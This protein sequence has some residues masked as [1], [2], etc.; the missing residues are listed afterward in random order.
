MATR[1]NT[2]LINPVTLPTHAAKHVEEGASLYSSPVFHGYSL[3]LLP[4]AGTD[5]E[6]M[7]SVIA[8]TAEELET[9]A[10]LPHL[11]VL[12]GMTDRSEEWLFE[13]MDMLE[14]RLSHNFDDIFTPHL[15]LH[16]LG[17][18][19]LFFQCVYAHPVLTKSITGLNK[20][21]CEVFER[22]GNG[23]GYDSEYMPHLSLIYG[24]LDVDTKGKAMADLAIDVIGKKFHFGNLQLWKT[25]GLHTDWKCVKKLE[26]PLPLSSDGVNVDNAQRSTIAGMGHSDIYNWASARKAMIRAHNFASKKSSSNVLGNGEEEKGE[27]SDK[28][29]G[30]MQARR[31]LG[32]T[33]SEG[34]SGVDGEQRINGLELELVGK[35]RDEVHNIILSSISKSAEASGAD[36]DHAHPVITMMASYDWSGGVAKA[37]MSWG[38]VGHAIEHAKD[39]EVGGKRKSKYDR[40]KRSNSII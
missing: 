17:A 20:V 6:Y 30:K 33:G 13:K 24:D 32:S 7:K 37:G 26:L 21:A 22:D 2:V 3:W 25:E 11:S 28:K 35:K 29:P 27:G 34:S 4:S 5:L 31:S 8:H 14:K 40:F 16:G 23:C 36:G 38:A 1:R 39:E 10:F 12:A 18:R 9:E 19:D 15:A